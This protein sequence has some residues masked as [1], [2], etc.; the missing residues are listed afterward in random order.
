MYI[1]WLFLIFL[2]PNGALSDSP[3]GKM[4]VSSTANKTSSKN[5]REVLENFRS[6][7]N[8]L[9][10]HLQNSS[11]DADPFVFMAL[12]PTTFGAALDLVVV[13]GTAKLISVK[14]ASE[15]KRRI[16]DMRERNFSQEM[17]AELF[18]M[19]ITVDR[20]INLLEQ[21]QRDDD[22]KDHYSPEEIEALA[23]WVADKNRQCQR[24]EDN[25]S[26]DS[27]CPDFKESFKR[28]G[29]HLKKK[30]GA[31]EV[32][33]GGKFQC[34]LE[35]DRDHCGFEIFNRKGIHQGEVGCLPD[36]FDP[37]RANLG[38]G[39][40]AQP[41]PRNHRPRSQTCGNK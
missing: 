2:I 13:A 21:G 22:L 5:L 30:K 17:V 39:S 31:W 25:N 20:A 15:Y 19:L 14:L 10:S 23:Q 7:I 26:P 12:V 16:R 24:K 29:F 18:Q 28:K 38:R 36:E 8:V 3:R 32:T 9:E 1:L 41:D 27:H 11:D 33:K 35:W 6:Q 34:C 4:G 37:C 40:H